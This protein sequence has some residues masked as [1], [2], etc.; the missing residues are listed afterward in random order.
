M[1]GRAMTETARSDL[2]HGRGHVIVVGRAPEKMREALDVLR[3][4]GFT[5][6]G[7]F[8][9]GEALAA[10]A[11]QDRLFAVVAGGSVDEQFEADLR[12]AGEPKGAQVVRA[13]IGHDDPGRHFRDHVLPQLEQLVGQRPPIDSPAACTRAR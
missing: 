7:T 4:A 10:I 3:S 1:I 8:N 11:A 12:A 5:A 9:R 6:T 2:N 13:Q